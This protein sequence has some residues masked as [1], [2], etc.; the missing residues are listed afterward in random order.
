MA[1]F[2][3]CKASSKRLKGENTTMLFYTTTFLAC[4]VAALLTRNFYKV[5]TDKSGSVNVSSKRAAVTDSSTRYQ[6]ARAG[7][8][9]CNGIPIPTAQQ[10]RLAALN[11]GKRSPAEPVVCRNRD[12]SWLV[13]EK[14]IASMGRSYKVRRR[15]E[16]VS[17]TLEMASQPFKREIAPW[18]HDNRI[19]I[20]PWEAS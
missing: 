9:T 20:R 19:A 18:A 11:L 15:V 10:S 16:P 3:R 4:L 7:F 12:A 13:H 8:K 5:L 17:P 14:K 6:K 1:V 2:M